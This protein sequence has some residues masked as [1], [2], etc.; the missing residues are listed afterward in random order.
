MKRTLPF[1]FA[2]LGLLDLLYGLHFDDRVS[3]IVGL[4]IIGIAVYIIRTK[5]QK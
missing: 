3:I 5:R 4:C 2:A 1:I